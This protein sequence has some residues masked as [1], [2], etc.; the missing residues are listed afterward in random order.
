M[1]KLLSY[2]Y[3]PILWYDVCNG[4]SQLNSSFWLKSISPLS[5]EF[6]E[7][8]R[9]SNKYAYVKWK[10]NDSARN[11]AVRIKSCIHVGDEDEREATL[12]ELT[13]TTEFV[14]YQLKTNREYDILV[15][16][17]SNSGDV[18]AEGVCRIPLPRQAVTPPHSV[19]VIPLT[20]TSLRVSW[21]VS[22]IVKYMSNFS[23]FHK[24]YS[25]H[26]KLLCTVY[27]CTC[28]YFL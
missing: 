20:K 25:H 1:T 21:K 5:V 10:W 6:Q 9:L 26:F 19:K 18:L 24:N 2:M 27:T 16:A 22:W 17:K 28:I 12:K 7:V 15:G 13:D 4:S 8:H 11:Y 14:A 23:D 3:T